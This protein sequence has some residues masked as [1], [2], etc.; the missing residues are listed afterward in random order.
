MKT[1]KRREKNVS[2]L[3]AK[4]SVKNIIFEARLL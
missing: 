1:N 4:S 2:T 3:A